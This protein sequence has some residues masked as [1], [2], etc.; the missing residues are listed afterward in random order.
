METLAYFNGVIGELDEV[1][2]PFNDR[3]HWF[4]DGVYDATSCG[5]RIPFAL[6]D[7]ID[8]FYNNMRLIDIELDMSKDE[9]SKLLRDL[10]LKVDSPKT[11]L[12][13]HATRGTANRSHVYPQ[14]VKPNLLIMIRPFPPVDL[15]HREKA[16]TVEDTRFLMCN[17]KTLNLLPNVLASEKAKRAGCEEAI[18]H[19]G[20]IVTE[21][22]HSNVHILKG[23]VFRTAPLTNLILPGIARKHLCKV[24][25]GLGV[26][27][28]EEA[29]TVGEMMDADEVIVSSS[30]T[31]GVG[32]D[33]IDGKPVG[34][35]DPQLLKRIQD[36][37]I[38]EFFEYTRQFDKAQAVRRGEKVLA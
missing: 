6:E 19:R 37:A 15:S 16:V 5:N 18:F 10:T 22:A 29:F 36:A 24:C 32:L 20:D 28:R 25:D 38:I 33:A 7:H 11:Q 3:S 27:V 4:G 26:P 2:V 8:R 1:M 30:S 31:F 14:G 9:L 34:G 12:Y 13:W 35:K 21:C 17:V 23:G